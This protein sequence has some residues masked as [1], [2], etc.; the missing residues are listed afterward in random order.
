MLYV[1]P[2]NLQEKINFAKPPNVKKKKK[3]ENFKIFL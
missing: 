3:L 1:R 2:E